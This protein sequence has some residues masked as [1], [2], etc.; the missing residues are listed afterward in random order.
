MKQV[1]KYRIL[2]DEKHKHRIAVAGLLNLYRIQALIDFGDVKAGDIGGYVQSEDNLSHEGNAWIYDDAVVGLNARV[3][4]NAI[5]RGKAVIIDN[6][7]IY[8]NAE[9]F[10]RGYVG[11][12][13]KVYDNARI[14][15]D[16]SIYGNA[17]VF[18]NAR[19]LY[20]TD[21]FENVKVHGKVRLPDKHIFHGDADLK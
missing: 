7:K 10:V 13:A 1:K 15:G 17:E 2:K 5:V 9:V 4:G 3:Y 16:A 14:S 21:V 12:W 20:N 11:G 8:D 18:E 6:A 19:V